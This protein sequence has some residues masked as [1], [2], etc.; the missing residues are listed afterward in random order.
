MQKT[1]LSYLMVTT[2]LLSLLMFLLAPHQQ[3]IPKILLLLIAL[4]LSAW[5]IW[6]RRTGAAVIFLLA[7]ISISMTLFHKPWVKD[8]DIGFILLWAVTVIVMQKRRDE[9][10][11]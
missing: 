11:F 4:G 1:L 7:A 10:D 2:I 9:S 6:L 3:F 8:L 5:Q